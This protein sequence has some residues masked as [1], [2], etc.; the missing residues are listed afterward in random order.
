MAIKP[1]GEYAASAS[2][3]IRVRR[4]IKVEEAKDE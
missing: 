4:T 1:Q 2:L 3:D